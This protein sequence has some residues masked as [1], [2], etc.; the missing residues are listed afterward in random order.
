MR[1]LHDPGPRSKTKVS[2]HW[3]R[4]VL[5]DAVHLPQ[6][7]MED[8]GRVPGWNEKLKSLACAHSMLNFK[9]NGAII[10]TLPNS[11]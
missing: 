9:F 4:A 2:G 1:V 5:Q 8:T 3:R 7:L 10:P 6:T 11:E